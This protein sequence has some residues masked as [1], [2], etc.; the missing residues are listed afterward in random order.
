M[1]DMQKVNNFCRKNSIELLIVFGSSVIGGKH[2]KSDLDI[3]LIPS[4]FSRF[5]DKLELLHE[6]GAI[7][8]DD[9]IDLV[10]VSVTTHPLVLFEIF[11]KG[12]VVY[13]VQPDSWANHYLRAWHLYLDTEQIRRVRDACLDRYRERI[14]HVA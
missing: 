9:E 7:Y 3:A 8:P 13:E 12:R 1:E 6:L 4:D 11:T 10:L 5:Y 2:S 14:Q